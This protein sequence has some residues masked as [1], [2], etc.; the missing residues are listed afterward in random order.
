MAMRLSTPR[1]QP[2]PMEQYL[3]SREA[4][5]GE[6]RPIESSAVNIARTWMNHPALVE[7]RR[8]LGR[9]LQGPDA[10][11]PRR[12]RELGIMRMG[13]QRQSDYEF[14][15][16]RTFNTV[17]G[18]LT[19]EEIKR[20]TLGPDAPGWTPFEATLLRTV[21]EM[22]NDAFISDRTWNELAAHYTPAQILDFIML[23]GQYWTVSTMLNS[24]GVQLEEGRKSFPD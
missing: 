5:G 8:S 17:D 19:E 14:G 2:V 11:L 1:I 24:V 4:S 15:Q 13:W 6:G 7:A 21:D 22:H 3:A 23:M 10:T 20:I 12:D 18:I 9:H 16:H